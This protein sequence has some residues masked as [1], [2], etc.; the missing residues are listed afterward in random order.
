MIFIQA[1]ITRVAMTDEDFIA[2][3]AFKHVLLNF[4]KKSQA[5]KSTMFEAI[6]AMQNF[7]CQYLE[8]HQRDII[9]L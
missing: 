4:N 5:I 9:E 1:N 2:E 7:R 3:I 6:V 8:R